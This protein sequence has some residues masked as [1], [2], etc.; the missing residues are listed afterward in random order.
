MDVDAA[1][2]DHKLAYALFDKVLPLLRKRFG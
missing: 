2:F 1:A